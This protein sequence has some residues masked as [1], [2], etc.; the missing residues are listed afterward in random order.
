MYDTATGQ[1]HPQFVARSTRTMRDQH[2]RE[3]GAI[4][5]NKTG[6]PVAPPAPKG[7]SAPVLPPE[8]YV[9]PLPGD[10]GELFIDYLAWHRDLVAA[11]AQY[12]ERRIGL[13]HQRNPEDPEKLLRSPTRFF[14]KVVGDRPLSP[15]V[16]RACIAGN[17]WIL[18]LSE[19]R[20]AWAD[21]L[22]PKPALAEPEVLRAEFPDA[23]EESVDS[24]EP[25]PRKASGV[26]RWTLSSGEVVRGTR[27]EAEAAEAAVR[28]FAGA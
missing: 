3:W 6:H 24:G 7:W 26:G 17:R 25:F 15:D 22:L 21:D 10:S 9:Q 13:A 27:E 1:P 14:E 2:G 28:E 8:K 12:E 5:E 11:F 23:E 20:P 19:A 18:G 4:V 16:A